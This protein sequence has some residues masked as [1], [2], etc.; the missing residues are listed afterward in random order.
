[1][2]RIYWVCLNLMLGS[3]ARGKLA[4]H[5]GDDIVGAGRL[6]GKGKSHALLWEWKGQLVKL[7]VE[8]DRALGCLF[9]LHALGL[10]VRWC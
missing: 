4:C 7:K 1:M 5:F 2:L 3:A 6:I 9:S 8:V 10:G